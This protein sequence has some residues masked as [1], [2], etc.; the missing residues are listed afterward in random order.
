MHKTPSH[1]F[2]LFQISNLNIFCVQ[3]LCKSYGFQ[4]KYCNFTRTLISVKERNEHIYILLISVIYQ[5][6]NYIE[7][8]QEVTKV[9]LK[10][11]AFLEIKAHQFLTYHVWIT[12]KI[13]AE[14]SS[15]YKCKRYH[16][17]QCFKLI[18]LKKKKK[19]CTPFKQQ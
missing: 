16:A 8:D 18:R 7:H 19:N 10:K 13:Y 3:C 14:F 5:N 12:R 9:Q 6:I 2:L 1:M 15:S 17:A 4:M 11:F